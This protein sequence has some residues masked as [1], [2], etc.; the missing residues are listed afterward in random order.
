[1]LVRIW[2]RRSY[3]AMISIFLRMKKILFLEMHKEAES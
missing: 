2:S 3:L 1:V